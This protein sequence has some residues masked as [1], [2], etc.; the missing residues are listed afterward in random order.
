[1]G[2]SKSESEGETQGLRV[3]DNS[4]S[5]LNKDSLFIVKLK[6]LGFYFVKIFSAFGVT[7]FN[8]MGYTQAVLCSNFWSKGNLNL[9]TKNT[10]TLK[11]KKLLLSEKTS[12]YQLYQGPEE[13]VAF[14]FLRGEFPYEKH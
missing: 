2:D 3:K 11:V 9:N 13:S 1:M 10:S 7:Y 5:F 4:A 12:V 6:R 14:N 8:P